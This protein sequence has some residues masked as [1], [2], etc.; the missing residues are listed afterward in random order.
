MKAGKHF[1]TNYYYGW[2]NVKAGFHFCS[3]L[4]ELIWNNFSSSPYPLC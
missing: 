3:S 2:I 1:T 4:V